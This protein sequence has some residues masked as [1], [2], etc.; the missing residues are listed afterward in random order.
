MLRLSLLAGL[1]LSLSFV[2][3]HAAQDSDPATTELLLKKLEAMEARISQLET[4]V[5]ELRAENQRLQSTPASTSSAVT[6]AAAAPV[7]PQHPAATP[8]AQVQAQAAHVDTIAPATPAP[9][10]VKTASAQTAEDQQSA[11]AA[12]AP[13]E[14]APSN[15]PKGYI[16]IIE[17]RA[18]ITFNL[19]TQVDVMVD[20]NNANTPAE[21]VTSSLPVQGQP[22]Y[23]AGLNS[24]VSFRQST[25][26]F[27]AL[28]ETGQGPLN[29][30]YAN[31]FMENPNTNAFGYYLLRFYG[32]WEGLRIG[33]GY[34]TLYDENAAP[35]T[36][37][38]E[39]PNSLMSVYN[40]QVRYTRTLI[41]GEEVSLLG[42]LA[43]ESADPSI[44][45][46]PAVSANSDVS[47]RAP[48]VIAV[49]G[50]QG[51]TWHVQGGAVLSSFTT[52]TA[53]V[54]SEELGWGLSLSGSW[55]FTPDDLLMV[56]GSIGSG[57]ANYIQDSEGLGLDAYVD[58]F[59]NLH[60]LDTYAFG[61]GYTHNWLDTLSSTF[62][63]GY[64]NVDD[65]AV[66]TIIPQ[67][68]T[69]Q[70]MHETYYTSGNLVWQPFS[71]FTIGAELLYGR[72]VAISGARGDDFR[73]QFTSRYSFNP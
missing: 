68:P 54:S 10:V 16:P 29:I 56:W 69:N 24:S 36:L 62:T 53:G 43:I 73:I 49:L 19:T 72:K 50:V 64:V 25:L 57:Y 33:Y 67:T 23:V 8:A 32:E 48:D 46:S 55:N 27:D 31:N 61:V 66:G 14:K 3:G 41:E 6:T 17:D 37:D 28:V 7:S 52:Q 22:T 4:E 34:T 26:G 35:A 38:Y 30:V 45:V 15:I 5:G 51:D 63:I 42:K 44:S 13:V 71:S 40:A 1:L 2:T 47:E 11:T 21:F 20:T 18:Y 12:L 70:I 39:G 9:A 59:G 58:A 65:A 60:T